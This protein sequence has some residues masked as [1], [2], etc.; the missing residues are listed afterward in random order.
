MRV[1]CCV[2]RSAFGVW[3]SAFGGIEARSAE[4]NLAWGE[5][6]SPRYAIKQAP[7]LKARQKMLPQDRAQSILEKNHHSNLTHL[8]ARFQR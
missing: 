8:L 5:S 4:E 6:A 3:R 7:A 2:L 1:A